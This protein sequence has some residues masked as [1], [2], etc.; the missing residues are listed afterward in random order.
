MGPRP[1]GRVAPPILRAV[2]AAFF[3]LDK[4]VIARASMLAF[5]RP[6]HRAGYVSRWLLLRAL[7]GQIVFRYLGADEDRM[8][9]MR[10]ASLRIARGWHRDTVQSL[11][12]ETLTEVIEPIVFAE[13]LELLREH[14]DAGRRVFLISSSPEEIVVPL[15]GYLGVDEAISTRAAVDADGRYTGEVEFYA[16]GPGK[17][18]AMHAVAERDGIDLS[19]SYAYSD[20]VTDIPMLET[21]GHPVAVN[22]D[23]DLRRVAEARGWEV[24]RFERPVALRARVPAPPTGPTM[25]VAGTLMAL[26][27]VGVASWWWMRRKP[28]PV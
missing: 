1:R 14:R 12:R 7:Y 5:G 13:A 15:A 3:D 4:T 21:V 28:A 20:S 2:E 26:V 27:T 19:E 6:L 8:E 18:A 11:V 24:R 23:R 9:K 10:T 17:A 22:P 16:Y 25:A